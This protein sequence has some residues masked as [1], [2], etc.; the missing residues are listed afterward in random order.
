MRKES[1]LPSHNAAGDDSGVTLGLAY[2]AL[3]DNQTQ[4][5]RGLAQSVLIAAKAASQP[6]IEARALACLAHCDR[7]S[8]R[9]KRASETSRKAVQLFERIGDVEGE[10]AALNILAHVSLL[11]GRNDETVEAGLL[12][13]RLCGLQGPHPQAIF[14]HNCLAVAYCWSSNFVRAKSA[15]E[16]AIQIAGECHPPISTYQSRLNLAWVEAARLVDERYRTN[17]MC[18]LDTM[19]GLVEDFQRV[20]TALDGITVTP[21]LTPLGGTVGLALSALAACWQR[22]IEDA[23]Q[24]AELAVRSLSGT[25]T[26]LDAL[27]HWVV[28]EVAWMNRDWRTAESALHEMRMQALVAEHE[29]LACVAH[30]L[31]A[32]IYEL[33]GKNDL[34]RLEHRALRLRERRMASE[35]LTGREAVVTSRLRERQSEVHLKQALSASKQFER[36]SLEDALTGIANRRFFEQT[37]KK[38]LEIPLQSDAPLAVAMIDVD[39]FKA[40]NDTYSHEVGDRVLKSLAGLLTAAV[41]DNDLPARLAGD[42]F[43]VLFD[44]A[45][46]ELANQICQRI[47]LAVTRFDWESLAKGLRVSISIGVSLAVKGDTVD[48]LLRRSDISM[49]SQKPG[50]KLR[51]TPDGAGFSN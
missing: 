23:G 9:L 27:V 49:Y 8:S 33:Q 29:Q 30:L 39:Q 44:S 36:W 1:K 21:T 48:T 6:Q 5:A 45:G 38:R 2:A 51:G 3:E 20:E 42:E 25:V 43:V 18:D 16:T 7:V 4:E 47:R 14:A 28:A 22:R 32:Q 15:L 24:K 40:I 13:A 37:L 26:W 41:R 34:A 35:S 17:Y 10:I 46:D 12:C 19:A 31:L 11:L 50:I